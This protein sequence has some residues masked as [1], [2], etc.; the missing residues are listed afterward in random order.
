MMVTQQSAA[1]NFGR[2]CSAVSPAMIVAIA[3]L[4]ASGSA[5]SFI[6]GA[7]RPIVLQNASQNFCSSAPQATSLP[8]R[9]G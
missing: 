1:A 6:S 9:V 2:Q 8:S 4:V 7:G 5:R 3:A